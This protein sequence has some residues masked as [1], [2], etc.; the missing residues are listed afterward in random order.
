MNTY[1]L[2]PW[3]RDESVA[4]GNLKHKRGIRGTT[5]DAILLFLAQNTK[6]D[7]EEVIVQNF[8]FFT[9]LKTDEKIKFFER[10]KFRVLH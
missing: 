4:E 10:Q 9:F 5:A 7:D 2:K 3:S 8:R 1:F 6:S